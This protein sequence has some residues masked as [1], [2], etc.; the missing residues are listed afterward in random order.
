LDALRAN[1]IE[2]EAK[3]KVDQNFNLRFTSSCRNA[4]YQILKFEET[5]KFKCILLPAYVGLSL[6]EGS[7]ILDPVVASGLTFHFYQVD[8]SLS[9]NI[10]DL[11]EKIAT[12]PDSLLLIANYFGW[13][14]NNRETV[15][16]I[17]ES[18]GVKVIEDNA[19]N[20]GDLFA[21]PAAKQESDYQI[22]SIHKFLG[23]ASGG[24]MRSKNQLNS[25][26][27]TI[28]R[29]DLLNFASTQ[30]QAV[31]QKRMKNYIDLRE[32]ID[33]LRSEKFQIMFQS[34][35]I[36][37]LNLPI[38]V[39]SKEK[40]HELYMKLIEN[41]IYPTALYHRLVPQITKIEFPISHDLSERILNLPVHQD[42]EQ[43]SLSE[44]CRIL[45]KAR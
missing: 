42:V 27:H 16:E 29:D 3:F 13:Q 14:I 40:R 4:L 41:N 12:F 25:I 34:L 17:C 21:N 18:S 32:Q 24:A 37:A 35:P 31:L 15:L 43:S 1:I 22:F 6:E 20:L 2:K 7:G 10:E 11:K 5:K 26:S 19:H 23:T 45:A 8:Q 28:D 39:E 44:I 33:G 38:L 9:P 30:L 36:S